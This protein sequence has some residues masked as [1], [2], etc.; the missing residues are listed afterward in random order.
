MEADGFITI[1]DRKK[2]MIIRGGENISC[3]EVEARVYEHPAVAEAA[4]FSVPCEQ[5]NERVGLVV[6]PRAGATIDPAALSAFVGETLAHFKR[7]ERVWVSP[8]PLPRLGT[9][10]F[11][12]RMIK[13]VALRHP[14]AWSA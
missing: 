9:E 3:L 2:D 13:M 7:P 1:V 5:L 12:K 10:K 4:V 8:A 11:D 14:P 6:Y